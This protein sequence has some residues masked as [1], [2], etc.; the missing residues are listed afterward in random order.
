MQ[1]IS[2][3]SAKVSKIENPGKNKIFTH[4]RKNLLQMAASSTLFLVEA[5]KNF[6]KNAVSKKQI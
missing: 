1:D 6:S 5:E 2:W 3:I 4:Y